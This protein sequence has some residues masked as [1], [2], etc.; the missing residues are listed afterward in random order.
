MARKKEPGI[1]AEPTQK[2]SSKRT[3]GSRVA[4]K[5]MTAYDVL[6][7][8]N[9]ADRKRAEEREARRLAVIEERKERKDRLHA[10]L[11]AFLIKK[12]DVPDEEL[13]RKGEDLLDE[14]LDDVRK[15]LTFRCGLAYVRFENYSVPLRNRTAKAF[16]QKLYDAACFD[17][18]SAWQ[19][20]IRAGLEKALKSR[21]DSS[22]M[23]LPS[24]IEN[25]ITTATTAADSISYIREIRHLLES[26][27]Q[28]RKM[29]PSSET[30]GPDNRAVD[31]DALASEDYNDDSSTDSGWDADQTEYTKIEHAAFKK[32]LP[33]VQT[34][35]KG[36]EESQRLQYSEMIDVF[37]HSLND[38]YPVS[39]QIAEAYWNWVDQRYDR[40]CLTEEL[41]YALREALFR[42]MDDGEESSAAE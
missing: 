19:G 9:A 26:Q 12:E 23:T 6:E 40:I 15:R 5:E 16:A 30:L 37:A 31:I 2:K 14:T 8:M 25:G 24:E 33:Q 18:D 20:G 34:W 41:Q 28:W 3:E 11:N 1:N 29:T 42:I 36:L 10:T 39:D 13:Y 27:P 4:K 17:A 22:D 7:M 35:I 21:G 32:I 38:A